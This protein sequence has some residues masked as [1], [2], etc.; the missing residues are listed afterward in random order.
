MGTPPI[1]LRAVMAADRAGSSWYIGTGFFFAPV[2]ILV[3]PWPAL[4]AVLWV[5]IAVAGLWLGLLGIAMA[6]G[7][8]MVLRSGQELSDDYWQSLLDYPDG[9]EVTAQQTVS[10]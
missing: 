7:L 5:I 6:T 8:A 9:P 1:W 10:R 4:T 2:L 3:S